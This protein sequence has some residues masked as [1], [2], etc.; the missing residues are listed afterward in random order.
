MSSTIEMLSGVD[1]SSEG[2]DEPSCSEPAPEQPPEQG[3][4]APQELPAELG[5]LTRRS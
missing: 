3:L 2:P 5:P 1:T 4:V